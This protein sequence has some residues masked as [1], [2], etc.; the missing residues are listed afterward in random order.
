MRH[1]LE[2]APIDHRVI[3]FDLSAAA[4]P[5]I[6]VP[7]PVGRVLS[8]LCNHKVL[9]NRLRKTRTTGLVDLRSKLEVRFLQV[10]WVDVLNGIEPLPNKVC[11][12]IR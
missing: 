9:R 7:T 2:A 8:Y 1:V 5:A 12:I 10:C 3:G 6:L 4:F 11:L